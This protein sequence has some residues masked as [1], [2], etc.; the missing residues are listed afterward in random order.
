[1]NKP[2]LYLEFVIRSGYE[3]DTYKHKERKEQL[4]I[5]IPLSYLWQ[6]GPKDLHVH[7]FTKEKSHTEPYFPK[8]DRKTGDYIVPDPFNPDGFRR[9][10]H[11]GVTSKPKFE[12]SYVADDTYVK[13]V[14]Q[15]WYSP[16]GD[17]GSQEMTKYLNPI[18]KPKK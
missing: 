7:F 4:F 6:E 3:A 17:E 16:C 2:P 1:M 9:C 18:K 14:M 10:Y 11:M 8:Y 12:P 15:H 13:R 5:Y